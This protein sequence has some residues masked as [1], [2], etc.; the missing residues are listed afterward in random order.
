M[1]KVKISAIC[2]DMWGTLC[3]GGGQKQWDDLQGILGAN[4]INKKIFLKLGE[5]SL[6]MHRW[7]LRDGIKNLAK[8]VTDIK[9][10]SSSVIL[11]KVKD[12]IIEKAFKSWWSYV[13]KAKP[14]PE[15]E[16]VLKRLKSKNLR[17]FII[18][19]TDVEAF[20]FKIKS[21]GWKKYFEKFFLSAKIGVL[22]PNNK[23]FQ[24]VQNYLPLPKNQILMVDDSLHHGVYSA[25][26]F[27][28]NALWL[29]RGRNEKDLEKIEDLSGIIRKL[30]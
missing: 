28:W 16:E 13:Q 17:L 20:D 22:K 3:E 21:L 2:F 6:L 8:K 14:Y 25:R 11:N 24:T 26:A 15:V 29:A 4:S 12:L 18:S 10:L 30:L 5:E 27:G 19:N 7:P 23:I 9:H 1:K